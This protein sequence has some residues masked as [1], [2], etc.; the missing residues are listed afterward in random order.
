MKINLKKMLPYFEDEEL[1][2]IYEKI[3]ESPDGEFEG[4]TVHDILTLIDDVDELFF[5]AVEM[6]KD[7]SEYLPYVSDEGFHKL[8]E[9]RVNDKYDI[10]LDDVYPF[11]P[12]EELKL[13]LKK[14]L[15]K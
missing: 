14:L 9:G 7:I 10:N 6:G 5:R 12:E 3:A 1:M 8:I 4:V 2:E 15:N 13:L 11:L